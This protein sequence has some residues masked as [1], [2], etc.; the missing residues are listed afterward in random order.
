MVLEGSTWWQRFEDYIW[1]GNHNFF[2]ICQIHEYCGPH[3]FRGSPRLV[4]FLRSLL[5][6]TM[7]FLIILNFLRNQERLYFTIQSITVC[8]FATLFQL[9][10]SMRYLQNLKMF[11]IIISKEKN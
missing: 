10:S 6:L 4:L 8:F 5:F 2:F 1:L 3:W 11:K 7:V 9:L